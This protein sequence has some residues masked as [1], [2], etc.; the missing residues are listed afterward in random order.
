MK[1]AIL[2]KSALPEVSYGTNRT[3]Y[4]IPEIAIGFGQRFGSRVAAKDHG[5]TTLGAAGSTTVTYRRVDPLREPFQVADRRL[6][7]RLDALCETLRAK[8]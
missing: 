8:Y 7:S 4:D 3:D 6:Q 5:T 1:N 2:E